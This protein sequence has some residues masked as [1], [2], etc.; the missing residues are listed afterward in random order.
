MRSW[1]KEKKKEKKATQEEKR[2][3]ADKPQE[4]YKT[5]APSTELP[6]KSYSSAMKSNLVEKPAAVAAAPKSNSSS[7]QKEDRPAQRVPPVK[8]TPAVRESDEVW[9]TIPPSVA[10]GEPES[11]ERTPQSKKRKHKKSARENTSVQE[12]EAQE[13]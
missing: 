2:A 5:T 13:V 11:W 4:V 8:E 12:K 3:V 10:S 9:E 1:E 6:K 7:S